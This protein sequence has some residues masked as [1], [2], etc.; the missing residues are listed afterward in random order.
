MIMIS[1]YLPVHGE[2]LSHEIFPV[3]SRTKEGQH[4]LLALAVS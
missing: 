1:L 3:F 2:Y 4:V